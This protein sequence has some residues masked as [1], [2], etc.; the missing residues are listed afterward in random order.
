MSKERNLVKKTF[1]IILR[2]SFR[3]PDHEVD[4]VDAFSADH[5]VYLAKQK[6]HTNI[7]QALNVEGNLYKRYHQ[8][9][10]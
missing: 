4:R 8:P 6:G 1:A 5:A 3:K 10:A 2:G 9:Q 7:A